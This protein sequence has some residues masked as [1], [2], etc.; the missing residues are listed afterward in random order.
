MHPEDI[1]KTAFRTH[2]GHYEFLVMSFGLTN[3]LDTFQTLMNRV[4]RPVLRRCLL[5]F[6]DD[7]LIYNPGFETHMKHVGMVLS[8]LRDNGLIANLKKCHFAQDK[9]DYLG[10]WVST[11]GVEADLEKVRAMLEWPA[12]SNLRELRGFLGLTGYYSR[13]VANYGTLAQP[14]TQ[15]T[16]KDAFL[17]GE[18]AQHAFDVLKHAM[19]TLPVLT[20]PDFS[21]PFVIET[22][23]SGTGLGAVLMQINSQLL[24]IVTLCRTGLG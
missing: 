11:S 8:V 16:K 14:L 7:I 13:F 1:Q 4:F 17:W 18:E 5:V 22:D 20:L 3:A 19:I 23:A 10:Y 21:Q 6:F 2:E 15:L 12:P 24:T 9:I